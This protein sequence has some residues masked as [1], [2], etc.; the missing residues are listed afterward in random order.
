MTPPAIQV[1]F[2]QGQMIV[3]WEDPE[4]LT[5]RWYIRYSLDSGATWIYPEMLGTSIKF[6]KTT[7]PWTVIGHVKFISL[8][9]NDSLTF[10]LY[11]LPAPGTTPQASK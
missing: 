5:T 7:N 3:Y 4:P 10:V 2:F 1:K 8:T 11:A 9:P 6:D